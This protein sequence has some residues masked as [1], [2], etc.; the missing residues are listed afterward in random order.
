[1]K[2]DAFKSEKQSVKYSWTSLI[3]GIIAILLGMWATVSPEKTLLTLSLIFSFSFIISGLFELA[4][5]L[6]NRKT[7]NGWGWTFISGIIDLLFGLLL[8]SMPVASILVLMFFVGF[9][10]LFHSILSI[11]SAIE[12]QRNGVRNWGLMLFL[13][14]L[15]VI[16]GFML[17]TNPV[18]ASGFLITVFAFSLILYGIQR[19]FY[20][21]RL[22]AL[23][24]KVN[25]K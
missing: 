15:G 6:L 21:D 4:F 17:I 12:L 23:I 16:L 9:W 22:R 10:I 2:N 5:A 25:E 3:V 18:F 19:I 20:A 14:I 24:K 13:S 11:G 7:L 8:L 1:M